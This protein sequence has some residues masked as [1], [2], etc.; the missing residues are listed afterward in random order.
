LFSEYLPRKVTYDRSR[1][2]V[3]HVHIDALTK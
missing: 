2:H 3:S 1:S